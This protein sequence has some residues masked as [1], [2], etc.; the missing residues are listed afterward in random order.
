MKIFILIVII[1]SGIPLRAQETK[2]SIVLS[3]VLAH[4]EQISKYRSAKVVPGYYLYPIDPGIEVLYLRYLN[5]NISLGTGICY[6]KGRISDF[7]INPDRFNFSEV[8]IPFLLSSRFKFDERNGLLITTGLYGGKTILRK[9]EFI[10]SLNAWHENSDFDISWYSDD[11]FFLD[12]YFGAGYSYSI[13]PKSS[14]S[15]MPFIKYRANTVWLN[16]FQEKLHYGVKLS[17]SCES[18]VKLLML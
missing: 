7:I 18:R 17:Y 14:I 12:I 8:S 11:V 15:I 4:Y 6:Q 1:I 2:N 16:D 9:A 13:S 5:K 3:G 10:D